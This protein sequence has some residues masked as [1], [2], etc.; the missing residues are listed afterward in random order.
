MCLEFSSLTCPLTNPHLLQDFDVIS[1]FQRLL[2]SITYAIPIPDAIKSPFPSIT[3]NYSCLSSANII[4]AYIMLLFT[5]VNKTQGHEFLHWCII[6]SSCR[7]WNTVVLNIGIT[8]FWGPNTSFYMYVVLLLFWG[9][10]PEV[11]GTTRII[12]DRAWKALGCQGLNLGSWAYHA[13]A[14]ALWAFSPAPR[15]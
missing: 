6:K 11:P 3:F 10:S 15:T 4:K 2:D 8:K 5:V 14:P 13:S 7:T 1:P 9:S 12:P